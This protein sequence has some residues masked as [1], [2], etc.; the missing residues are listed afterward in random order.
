[1][2][3]MAQNQSLATAEDGSRNLLLKNLNTGEMVPLQQVE[4]EVKHGGALDPLTLH[5]M[6]RV[7]SDAFNENEKK[8]DFRLGGSTNSLGHDNGSLRSTRYALS[9]NHSYHAFR[10]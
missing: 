4:E 10:Y 1:M 7:G 8:A 3:T 2:D 5:I 9:A 6:R